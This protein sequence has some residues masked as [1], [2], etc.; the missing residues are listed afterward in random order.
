MQAI[1][2]ASPIVVVLLLMLGF[3]VSAAWAGFSGLVLALYLA[4]TRESALQG[5]TFIG[6]FLESAF[7]TATI[8]W[9]LL[10]ALAIYHL[11]TNTGAIAT[12]RD[13]LSGLTANRT[14]LAILIGWFFALFL[15]GVAGFGTPVALAAPLLVGFGFAPVPAVAIALI[16]HAS[17]VAFGAVGT[18]VLAQADLTGV[19]AEAIA[20]WTGPVNALLAATMIG[21]VVYAARAEDGGGSAAW[22][23]PALAAFLYLLPMAAIAV[24]VG[25][26]LPTI[27][28]A[29]IGVA[30]FAVAV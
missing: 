17:G 15:E 16:G 10:P 19:A 23:W 24:L 25:P 28:G 12:I 26:E 27:G 8:L 13:A 14:L 11:Q 4:S 29:L 20:I 3:R 2:A 5:W 30:A 7:L 21:F 9:I 18:P 22:T 6:P 1:L